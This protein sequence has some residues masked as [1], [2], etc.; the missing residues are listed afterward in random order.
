MICWRL[1]ERLF[2]NGGDEN[3]EENFLSS[4]KQKNCGLRKRKKNWNRHKKVLRRLNYNVP[5]LNLITTRKSRVGRKNLSPR[6]RIDLSN[7]IFSHWN[8]HFLTQLFTRFLNSMTLKCDE[9][10]TLKFRLFLLCLV[11]S[12]CR[13]LYLTCRFLFRISQYIL[14]CVCKWENERKMWKRRK[15]KNWK[16]IKTKREKIYLILIWHE[17]KEVRQITI[18]LLHRRHTFEWNGGG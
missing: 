12:T 9:F 14:S 10:I 2:Q 7:L 15:K 5:K 4:S 16:S 13:C 17:M 1:W 8:S 6:W 11:A 3:R 18:F